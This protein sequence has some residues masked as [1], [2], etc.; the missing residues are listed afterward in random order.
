[1][2]TQKIKVLLSA[3]KYQSLSKAAEEFSYTPSAMS[4]MADSVEQ[5]LG[6]KILVRTPQGISLTPEGEAL[7]NHLIAV[8]DAEKN[9]LTVA[10]KLAE[11]K[12]TNL[13][14]GTIASISQ[15]ILPKIISEFRAAHPHIDISISV[16]TNLPRGLKKDLYDL[17]IIDNGD[18]CKEYT[19]MP[20]KEDRFVAIVP[21]DMFREQKKISKEAL[22]PYT[23]IATSNSVVDSHIDKSNFAN[24]IS[25]K[26][27]DSISV[28]YMVQQGVGISI[29]PQ[30]IVNKKIKGVKILQ[31]EDPISRTIGIA[32]KKEANT[33]DATQRF[34]AFLKNKK[35]I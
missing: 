15:S 7:Y 30:L 12:K 34:I 25:L 9:L 4:H 28:I 29:L 6:V 18:C 17:I 1:M 24:V 13:R 22:Y 10:K 14:I 11:S 35:N 21:S 27:V 19:W 3:I 32:C 8:V 31:L 2:D 5:E 16:D 23:Y 20:I 26:A 33:T